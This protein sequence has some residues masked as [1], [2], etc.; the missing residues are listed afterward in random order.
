LDTKHSDASQVDSIKTRAAAIE[1]GVRELESL[2]QGF[3]LK[4]DSV[5]LHFEA[6]KEELDDYAQGY[7]G[8]QT[9]YSMALTALDEEKHTAETY[10]AAFRNAE[11]EIKILK[12]LVPDE[13]LDYQLAFSQARPY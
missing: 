13:Q 7:D 5:V 11:V 6:L 9:D 8:L 10:Y 1:R 3:K 2:A 12:T 4:V